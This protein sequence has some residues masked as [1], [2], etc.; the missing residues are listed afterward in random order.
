MSTLVRA[1]F[2]IESSS[3]VPLFEPCMEPFNN[4]APIEDVVGVIILV[5]VPVFSATPFTYRV[6]DPALFVTA[7]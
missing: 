6:I 3:I 1:L 5:S 2:Q 4:A 7:I